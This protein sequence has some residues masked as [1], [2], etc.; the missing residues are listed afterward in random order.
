MPVRK[1]TDD[2]LSLLLTPPPDETLDER[3][4]RLEKET[5]ARRISDEI[6]EQIRRDHVALKKQNVLK[7]LLLGQSESGRSLWYASCVFKLMTAAVV[8]GK[9]Q[10]SKVRASQQNG[11]ILNYD[12]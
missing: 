2:P 1:D 6:D 3:A 8:Q 9:Q 12:N 7:M 5:E 11:D 4:I 10:H